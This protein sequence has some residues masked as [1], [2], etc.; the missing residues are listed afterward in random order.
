[1]EPLVNLVLIPDSWSFI[2]IFYRTNYIRFR[3]WR[4]F[5]WAR[6]IYIMWKMASYNHS[7]KD[8]AKY[9]G[10]ADVSVAN[11]ESPF[12]DHE[13]YRNFN[14]KKAFVLDASADA[15]SSLR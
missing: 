9:I 14:G 13:S 6:A 12:V 4:R 7:F 11:L 3:G 10:E 2:V 8:V 1:M 15:A 5:F